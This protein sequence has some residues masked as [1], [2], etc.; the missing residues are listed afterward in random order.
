MRLTADTHVHWYP[1]YDAA[2]FLEVASRHLAV[3]ADATPGLRA[4]FLT[5][6][7]DCHQFRGLADGTIPAPAGWSVAPLDEPVSCEL[8]NP[9]HDP[10]TLVSGRQVVAQEGVEVLCLGVLDAPPDGTPARGVLQACREAGGFPV[11][12]WSP[13][14]WLGHRGRFILDLV[15]DPSLNLGVGDPGHRPRGWPESASVQLARS[16]RRLVLAGTDPLP[17]PG[18]EYSVARYGITLEAALDPRRPFASLLPRLLYGDTAVR[19]VGR[20]DSLPRFVRRQVALRRAKRAA[21][22]APAV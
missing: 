4:L 16:L 6:R 10:I 13:G 20:R 14:K 5:E 8:R 19:M 9:A 17:A 3:L 7:A 1:S 2:L 15:R 11:L 18:E 12:P 21:N 22:S